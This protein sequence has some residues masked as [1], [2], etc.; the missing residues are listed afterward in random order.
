M[1]RVDKSTQISNSKIKTEYHEFTPQ[2]LSAAF[3]YITPAQ[4]CSYPFALFSYSKFKGG[5]AH[6]G[7]STIT[8]L[9]FENTGGNVFSISSRFFT[10]FLARFCVLPQRPCVHYT[11]LCFG[12]VGRSSTKPAQIVDIF[13]SVWD[14]SCMFISGR[15]KTG[16]FSATVR[17]L[18]KE[19]RFTYCYKMF[20]CCTPMRKSLMLIPVDRFPTL[21][22]RMLDLD[23]VIIKPS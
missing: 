15:P 22:G 4:R 10:S 16:I 13:L 6:V 11:E 5:A 20:P 19:R 3:C 9:R 21:I 14:F 17:S 1:L 7:R 8:R 23:F 12:F 18:F 2:I